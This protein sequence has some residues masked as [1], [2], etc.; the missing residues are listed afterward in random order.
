NIA[1]GYYPVVNVDDLDEA[2]IKCTGTA[3]TD[4][5]LVTAASGYYTFPESTTT[6]IRCDENDGCVEYDYSENISCAGNRKPSLP[7]FLPPPMV[8]IFDREK[9]EI[10]Y[11]SNKNMVVVV[12]EIVYGS[13]KN[14]V[15]VVMVIVTVNSTALPECSDTGGGSVCVG[16]NGEEQD[17]GKHC[18]SGG[19]IYANSVSCASKRSCENDCG[20]VSGTVASTPEYFAFDDNGEKVDTIDGTTASTVTTTYYC[21]VAENSAISDCVLVSNQLPGGGSDGNNVCFSDNEDDQVSAQNGAL[22]IAYE[23]GAKCKAL[24]GTAN[25]LYYFDQDYKVVTDPTQAHY[26]YYCETAAD[27]GALSSCTPVQMA[28]VG[29]VINGVGGVPRMCT[30]AVATE[31][32]TIGTTTTDQYMAVGGEFPDNDGEAIDIHISTQNSITKMNREKSDL[33]LPACYDSEPSNDADGCHDLYDAVVNYCLESEG[34]IIYKTEEGACKKITG[35]AQDTSSFKYFVMG[36]NDAITEVS[37]TSKPPKISFAYQCTIGAETSN[38][39]G[40]ASSCGNAPFI[41]CSVTGS[42]GICCS[43]LDGEDCIVETLP[44][45]C[46]AS[47]EATLGK[48]SNG[49]FICFGTKQTRLPTGTTTSEVAFYTTKYNR[50]V[51]AYG[52]VLLK[53]TRNTVTVD[54]AGTNDRAFESLERDSDRLKDGESDG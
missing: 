23:G 21:Q 43:G 34:H 39:I 46:T 20:A 18:I 44:D 8:G 9:I 26:T 5:S 32:I 36:D 51:D 53:L 47:Y 19:V 28:N 13:N 33:A 10:V 22:F 38:G 27:T 17:D 4:C 11:G 29:G 52:M 25:T 31:A 54:R 50:Y 49:Y 1:A 3:I 14:M 15:V 48:D 35:T 42:Y 45:S 30:S 6:I 37:L 40:D 24:T 41:G 7:P 16:N 12:M 2:L